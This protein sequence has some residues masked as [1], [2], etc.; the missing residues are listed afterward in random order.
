VLASLASVDAL[1]LFE[2]DTPLELIRCLRP[3]VLVKGADYTIQTVV[4]ASDVQSWGG[5][6]VLV[7]LVPEQST[8]RLVKKMA[9]EE[10]VVPLPRA[11]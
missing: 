6:V 1:V 11:A 9:S 5:R 10:P 3:D 2:Q 7:D 4:G 8:T